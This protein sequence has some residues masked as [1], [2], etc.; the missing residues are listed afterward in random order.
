MKNESVLDHPQAD[1]DPVVWTKV[2]GL[3]TLTEDAERK[4]ESVVKWVIENAGILGFSLHIA[5]SITSNQYSEKSDVDLHFCSDS[6]TEEKITELNG[7]LRKQFDETYPKDQVYIGSHKIEIYFQSN[8]FQDMMSIGCYDFFKKEWIVGPEIIPQDHDPYAEYYNDNMK[9]INSVIEDIRN[10]I[11]EVYELLMV[12]Q[13]TTDNDF[14]EYAYTSLSDKLA[15]AALIFTKAREYRKISSSPT[16]KEDALTKRSSREWKVADSAFK[17]LD[18]FGY[19]GILRECTKAWESIQGGEKTTEQIIPDLIQAISNNVTKNPL[20]QNVDK[21]LFENL[22]DESVASNLATILTIVSMIA[23]PGVTNAKSLE[24]ELKNIPQQSFNIH[25]PAVTKAINNSSLEDQKFGGWSY[26]N[27]TNLIAILAYNEG[28][29]DYVK[30]NAKGEKYDDRVLQAIIWTVINRAGGDVNKFAEKIL[31]PSQYFGVKNIK[32]RKASNYQIQHP[33]WGYNKKT[34]DQCNK[35]AVMAI[36]G[37]LPKPKDDNGVDFG[38]R[39]M[40]ANKKIDNATSYKKWGSKCDFTL[41]GS[42]KH[43]YGYDKSHDGFKGKKLDQKFYEIKSGDSLS[44]I[45]KKFGT[46]TKTLLALNPSIKNADKIR[47][48]QKIRYV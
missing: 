35:F 4:I 24:K 23:I 32:N 43:Y 8:P 19:L 44:K 2:D 28:M 25:N 45:A 29:I 36:K 14:K 1:L 15:K 42:T 40:I 21:E 47:I 12:L 18:K 6:L 33:G 26:S 3:Y 9:Y 46:T 34:W 30:A 39:N 11:L 22:Q 48:G 5:G 37:T 13:N 7:T 16:S 41:G 20:V 38:T 31:E 27:L 17:L 10:V